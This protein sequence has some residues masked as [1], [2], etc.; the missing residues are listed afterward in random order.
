MNPNTK[1]IIIWSSVAVVLGVGGYF[2]YDYFK[3]RRDAKAE[4]ERK[5][6][7]EEDAKNQALVNSNAP[8]VNPS[9]V[10]IPANLN[11]LLTRLGKRA[12]LKGFGKNSFVVVVD[13]TTPQNRKYTFNFFDNDV[14][15]VFN[16]GGFEIF[17]GKYS[18]GGRAL[19]VTKDN[20]SKTSKVGSNFTTDSFWKT[21]AKLF[22]DKK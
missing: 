4:E 14:Y 16:E 9:S 7:E 6:Q 17:S 3:K 2:A 1:K 20:F 18:D 22:T 12:S 13:W 5:K 11:L 21:G 19:S 15:K 8:S 10:S